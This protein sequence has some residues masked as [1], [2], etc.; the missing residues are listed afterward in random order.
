MRK[1]T[2]FVLSTLLMVA[3]RSFAFD[4]EVL[5][6]HLRKAFNI[7]SS[8][9]I[10]I[11]DPKP[12]QFE[13]FQSVPVTFGQQQQ[14]ILLSKDDRY[15]IVGN[16]MDTTVDP[17]KDRMSKINLTK[18]PSKGSSKAPV[19]IVEFSDLQCPNCVKAH[20]VIDAKL[21]NDYPGNQVR[22]VFKHFP[23]SMHEWAEP[24]AVAAD[25]AG[26]QSNAAFWKMIDT[27]YKNG[28]KSLKLDNVKDQ[29]KKF[30]AD[31]KLD[32]KKFDACLDD[33]AAIDKVRKEKQEAGVLGINA[34]PTFVVNGRFVRG[35]NYEGLKSVIDEKLK[36][37]PVKK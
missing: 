12:S 20:E 33:Q 16:V 13:V 32:Q 9:P 10:T 21:F 8:V 19:T 37:T 17:D 1:L 18:A 11:G 25:C 7:D 4:K 29:V 34:T 2:L 30:A 6:T 28:E 36:E 26:Q 15:Y 5:K 14:T 24:A 3:P 31:L 23:L 27:I 22:L 35:N